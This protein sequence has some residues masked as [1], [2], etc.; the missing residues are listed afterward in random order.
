MENIMKYHFAPSEL[1]ALFA[2]GITCYTV[3]AAKFLSSE[4]SNLTEAL[5]DLFF[6]ISWLP[7]ALHYMVMTPGLSPEISIKLS[8]MLSDPKKF[9][10]ASRHAAYY[11]HIVTLFL[12]PL[13]MLLPQ[14]VGYDE[15]DRPS[16]ED[17]DTEHVGT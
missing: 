9:H 11:I 17:E 16:E 6:Y 3:T 15:Q 13:W 4:P 14:K 8:D 12:L 2:I 7:L 10:E 5:A 1:Y